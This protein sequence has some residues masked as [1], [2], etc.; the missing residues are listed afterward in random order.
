MVIDSSQRRAMEEFLWSTGA[1][2]LSLK[3]L[4]GSLEDLF[5]KLVEERH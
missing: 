3:Q 1:D 5:L 2:I 4:R